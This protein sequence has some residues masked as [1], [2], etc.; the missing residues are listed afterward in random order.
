MKHCIIPA[1]GGSKRIPH[2]NIRL[3][4]D[5]P[6]IAYSIEAAKESGFFD[7]I[8]VSTDSKEI[9]EI[10]KSYGAEVPFIRPSLLAD[11]YA[12]TLPVIKHAIDWFDKNDKGNSPE[13]VCCL[14]ATAP[15]VNAASILD[16]YSL[17]N[18][19]D[20]DYCF[21]VTSFGYPIQRALKVSIN[22]RIEMFYPEHSDTRSQDLEDAYHDAGQFYWGKADAFKQ[23]KPLLSD[24]AVPFVLPRYLVQ[25]IDTLED[26][27]RAEL[28]HKALFELENECSHG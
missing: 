7:K 8:V 6:I 15:F 5:K 26:W 14:Y 2:K 12:G 28:M 10:A 27:R 18:S 20:V 21:T 4:R 11:D 13:F 23:M 16:A 22:K 25:D 1:R 17:L 19:E 9:A 3:F 24:H